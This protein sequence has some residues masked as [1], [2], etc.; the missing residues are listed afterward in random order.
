MRKRQQR[1]AVS[2]QP[3]AKDK[4]Q[5]FADSRK[6]KAESSTPKAAHAASSDRSHTS[7]GTA[8][9]AFQN[10]MAR[11]GFGSGNLTEGANYPLT[12]LTQ[13]YTLML[14]LYRSHWI[15]RKIIDTIPEDMVKNWWEFDGQ[16]GPAHV[17]RFRKAERKTRTKAAIL[18]ALKWGR[19]FGGAA[20][21]M[22]VADHEDSLHEPLSLDAVMPGSYRGLLVLD[23]W[24]G[25]SP[26]ADRIEDINDP[27]FG[28]PASYTI[29]LKTGG[30]MRVHA[31]RVLRFTGRDLP[32]WEAEAEMG[33]GVSEIEII[34]DELKKRDNTSWN[35]SSL[36]FLANI[37]VLK[38]SDLAE[39]LAVGSQSAQTRLYQV[40]SAQNRLMSNMGV[41]LLS[42]DDDFDTKQYSFSGI[43]DIYES[44]MLDLSGA[45]EIPATRLFGRAPA[46]LNATGE[47]DEQNYY[48]SLGQKQESQ[49]T[50]QMDKLMPVIA[51]SEWG[52]MPD[53]LGHRWNPAQTAKADK[54]AELASKKTSAINESYNSGLISQKT[55]MRE[56]RA[57]SDETGMY[58]TI[59]DEDIKRADESIT[60]RGETEIQWPSEE[61]WPSGQEQSAERN[62]AEAVDR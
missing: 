7:H 11:L 31:S 16:V 14:S 25:I 2:R 37:R 61:Q 44:F 39:L 49:L 30:T 42:K 59:S 3:S 60:P 57:M 5:F 8:L 50:P 27:D 47:S 34:Y 21:V 6:L 45:A 32:A 35:I 53:D 10:L 24:S 29:T 9:D 41:Q 40:L 18:R 52:L 17:D 26:S 22:M 4:S 54:R 19:L 62:G 12:R 1:A 38:M 20:A 36:I 28:L 43:N 58:G 48:D 46:G 23:R 33:W 13:N 55:G 56:L 51:M 15:V